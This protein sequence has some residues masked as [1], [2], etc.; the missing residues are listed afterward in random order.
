MIRFAFGN[1]LR[2]DVEAV[3]NPV[4]C[5]GVMGK[6]LALQFKRAFPEIVEPYENACATGEIQ[7]GRVQT[8]DR[9]AG[10]KPRW[11][12]NV[13]TKRHWR[14]PSRLDDVEAGAAALAESIERQGIRSVAVAPLGCGNGGLDWFVVLPILLK[15]LA[16][17]ESVDVVIY[18]PAGAPAPEDMPNRSLRPSMTSRRAGVIVLFAEFVRRSESF[19]VAFQADSLARLEMQKLVYFAQVRS[20]DRYWDFERGRYGPYSHGLERELRSWEGHFLIGFGDATDKVMELRP[21]RLLPDAIK[22]ADGERLF[23]QQEVIDDV[24]KLLV[25]WENTY[26]L[27][28]LATVLF[29]SECKLASSAEGAY[30]IIQKWDAPA[31]LFTSR[32]VRI[33]WRHLCEQGWIADNI[34]MS[35]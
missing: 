12:L 13:P 21:V 10:E 30:E 26:E 35:V 16:P 28:L 1:L 8:I 31:R 27:E 29:L 6:G 34:S 5:V 23:R 15:H 9:G 20:D 19:R 18:P 24:L 14:Q 22:Q 7:P 3:V 25:G 33:A 32:H 17:L 11:I 2:A 4:N